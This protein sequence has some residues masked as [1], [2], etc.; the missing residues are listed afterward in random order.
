MSEVWKDVPGYGD[1]YEASSLGRIRSKER[2]VSKWQYKAQ[3]IINMTYPARILKGTLGEWGHINLHLS[4]DGI[5]IRIAA[6]TLVLLA[7][8]GRCPLGMEGCHNNGKAD[9]NRPDNLRWDTHFNNN[10]DRKK[11]GRY[12]SRESHHMVKLTPAQVHDIRTSKQ[13]GIFMAKKYSIGA[14]QVSRIRNGQSWL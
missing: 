1:H 6:H 2:I 9:D 11:H 7:F 5:K 14:S 12:A 4:I 8:K 3:C 10:Q 13:T